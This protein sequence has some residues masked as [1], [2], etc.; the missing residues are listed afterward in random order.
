MEGSRLQDKLAVVQEE[1]L[2]FTILVG[3]ILLFKLWIRPWQSRQMEAL[4]KVS[5]KIFLERMVL[6]GDLL[7]LLDFM[8]YSVRLVLL[9]HLSQNIQMPIVVHVKICLLKL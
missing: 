4:A 9:A 1:E 3:M 8:V 2:S 5:I 6:F 7:V